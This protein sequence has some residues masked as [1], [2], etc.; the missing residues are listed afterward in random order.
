V[1]GNR[2]VLYLDEGKT[3]VERSDPEGERVRA[4]IYPESGE[5]QAGEKK[6][7]GGREQ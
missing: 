3:I 7:P 2:I 5:Q 4:F 1:T 6:E